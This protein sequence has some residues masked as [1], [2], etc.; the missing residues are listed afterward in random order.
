MADQQLG[1][2]PRRIAAALG[3]A[4]LQIADCG[5]DGCQVE[6]V[7]VG[8]ERTVFQPGIAQALCFVGRPQLVHKDIEVAFHD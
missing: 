8:C 7:S 3:E 6:R 4:S 5:G 2:E 1:I